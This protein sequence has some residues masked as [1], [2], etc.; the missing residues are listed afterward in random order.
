MADPDEQLTLPQVAHLL[1]L[2]PSTIRLW[3]NDRR[4][5][6][7]RVG[8]RWMVRRVDLEQMLAEQPK[9]GHPKRRG[10]TPPPTREEMPADWSEVPEQ[11]GLYLARS[12]EPIKGAR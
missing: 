5:P 1:G 7:E 10:A 3:V 11:A 6:A 8:R 4:L 12:T 2:N 9:I